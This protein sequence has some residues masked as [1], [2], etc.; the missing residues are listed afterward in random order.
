MDFT[1]IN[2]ITNQSNYLPTKKLK[3]LQVQ[4]DYK[5]SDIRMVK[6]RYGDKYIAE[7]QSEYTIFLPAR[8]IKAF[9]QNPAIFEEMLKSTRAGQLSMK[10]IGGTWNGIEFHKI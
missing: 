3:D 9:E 10:Y 8:V 7:I 2:E 5:I 6:T 4:G 1:K